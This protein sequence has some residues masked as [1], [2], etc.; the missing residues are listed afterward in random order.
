MLLS[1]LIADNLGI[2]TRQMLR[3]AGVS[4]HTIRLWL[5][6]NRLIALT[7]NTVAFPGVHPE[8][9]RAVTMGGR[10]ACVSAAR[11]RGIWVVDD[12]FLHVSFRANKSHFTNDDASPRPRT[13]WDRRPL[14]SHGD[15]P[16]L[17][18]GRSMLAH[19]ANCQPLEYAVAAFDSAVRKGMITLE[20]LRVLASVRHGRF[21]RVAGFV[22]ALADSGLESITRVRLTLADVVCREQ[23]TIDGHPVDLLIGERLI[24]QLDGKQHLDDPIRLARDRRQ[25]R[26]LRAM[27]YE[28]LRYSYAEVVYDWTTTFSEIASYIA[29]GA[30]RSAQRAR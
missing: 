22:S 21:E 28:V 20:E 7:R 29:Q 23:I 9:A 6:D 30:H 17:E 11:L 2:V 14:D 5:K 15:I 26:R 24:I 25:D 4:N 10:L 19:I 1:A 27:G 16:A 12:G 3:D 8:F 13:H 18:S